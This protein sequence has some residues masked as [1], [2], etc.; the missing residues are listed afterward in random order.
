MSLLYFSAPDFGL[1]R[2]KNE[3][4]LCTGVKGLSLIFF[5]SNKC[6]FCHIFTPIF[7]EL[8]KRV[9]GCMFGTINISEN[10][11]L[12]ETSK[13]STTP[14]E[15]VPYIILYIDGVPFMRYDGTRSLEGI[16]T[17]VFQV[18]ERLQKPADRYS[19]DATNRM[20][21]NESGMEAKMNNVQ[22]GEKF[23]EHTLG[24]PKKQNVCYLSLNDAY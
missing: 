18:A 23:N 10:R 1:K 12:V 2:H 4:K 9:G 14:L 24:Q 15:Y 13:S 8:P 21:P 11:D 19:S 16:K 20:L 3:I 22:G 5:Y 7:K 17:F 6:E